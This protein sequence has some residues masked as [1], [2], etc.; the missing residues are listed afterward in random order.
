MLEAKDIRRIKGAQR[1]VGLEDKEYR[2]LLRERFCVVSCKDL[3]PGQ[4]GEVVAA[5][6]E[7]RRRAGWQPGQ[8][9][10]VR[11]YQRALGWDA[12]RL[13]AEVHAVTGA[14][15][16]DSTSLGQ[17]D[18]DRVMQALEAALEG[19]LA[20]TGLGWPRGME[21]R[22]WRRRNAGCNQRLRHRVEGLWRALCPSLAED[23]RTERYLR[24]VVAQASGSPCRSLG[25][26]QAY[27]ALAGIEALKAMVARGRGEAAQEAAAVDADG[28]DPFAP[29]RMTPEQLAAMEA[30]Y[31]SASR[32]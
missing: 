21:P 13:R 15:R 25:E 17:D 3:E 18:F 9:A 23:D 10:V 14:F 28:D 7:G 1:K 8:L 30:R 24:G 32:G 26:M 20:A 22:Y 2:A 16:E 6:R 19:H 29:F 12:A 11:R 27:Q 5:I 4:V 31:G